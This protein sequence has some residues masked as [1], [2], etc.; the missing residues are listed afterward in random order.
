[1]G[2]LK[3]ALNFN[4]NIFYLYLFLL[5]EFKKLLFYYSFM[6]MCILFT[7]T[8]L[9]F[10]CLQVKICDKCMKLLTV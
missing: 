10:E 6:K 5:Y 3:H 9:L 4:C 1:M 8:L 2:I 7:K